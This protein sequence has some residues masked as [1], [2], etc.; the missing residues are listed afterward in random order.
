MIFGDDYNI[1]WYK[2]C[3]KLSTGYQ[4]NC[5]KGINKVTD[6]EVCTS[7]VLSNTLIYIYRL[8]TLVINLI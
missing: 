6:G 8:P 4:Q 3:C 7:F 1:T 2:D 5:V